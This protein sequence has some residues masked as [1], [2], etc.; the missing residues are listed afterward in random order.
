MREIKFR[1]KTKDGIW[2]YGDLLTNHPHQGT[3]IH[4]HGCITH[5]V[6]PETIGQ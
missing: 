5:A 6:I 1:G 3:A 2:F 4:E